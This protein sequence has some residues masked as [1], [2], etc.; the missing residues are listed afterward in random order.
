LLSGRRQR[1]QQQI[2]DAPAPS[3]ETGRHGRCA[4]VAPQIGSGQQERVYLFDLREVIDG[5][6]Q[7]WTIN[8]T[9]TF[10][11]QALRP[12]QL[13]LYDSFWELMQALYARFQNEA[14]LFTQSKAWQPSADFVPVQYDWRPFLEQYSRDLI[15]YEQPAGGGEWPDEVI[16]S[17]WVGYAGASEGQ[18]M[19]L[20][21]R[22]GA[23][24][25]PSYR[26]FLAVTNG[27]R[28]TGAFI[29]K[30]WSA[31][32]VDWFRVRNK[33]WVD[34]W[35]SIGDDDSGPPEALEMK[36]A[37]EINDTGDSAILLLNPQVITADGEWE[38][39]FFSNWNPGARRYPSFWDLMHDQCQTMLNFI[40]DDNKRLS[41]KDDL[42]QLPAK[43]PGLATK[44][45]E[46]AAVWT[47]LATGFGSELN[48]AQ[49]QVLNAVAEQVQ[50]LI[51][52]TR[53]PAETLTELRAIVER[54]ERE[55]S[56]AETL[57]Q[58]QIESA[59]GELSSRQADPAQI[60]G[61]LAELMG[62]VNFGETAKG[63]AAKG[64]AQ[65]M[66]NAAAIVRW[67]IN[68]FPA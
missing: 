13:D 8:K 54:T 56:I 50:A 30:M 11:Q 21:G 44:L 6:W 64:R 46:K 1:H 2:A 25:P 42:T 14:A 41:I 53:T 52:V 35:N 66:G 36:T 55:Q 32:E 43:L 18:I 27:W 22:I 38:A 68:D 60:M 7:A 12:E 33:E 63:M 37:L 48:E 57:G 31:E 39:W 17:G 45:R 47:S 62:Q 59:L 58:A 3:G 10:M 65:G 29:Y 19:A 24:L 61:R 28:C 16:T 34:I 51:D 5:E 40:A 23:R 9:Q 49:A 20:E 15:A 4:R 26:Q 67:F